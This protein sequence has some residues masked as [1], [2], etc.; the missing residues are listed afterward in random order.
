MSLYAKRLDRGGFVWPQ[1]KE[2]VVSLSPAMVSMLLE[3]IDWRHPQQQAV[4]FY[5]TDYPEAGR[6]VAELIKASGF[7]PVL[8]GGIDQSI[9]IEVGGDLHEYG[10][11]AKLV[12]AAEAGTVV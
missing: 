5:A 8:V 9:R 2:G 3:G 12:S 11:L 7:A 10:M 4:L 1:A 6:V